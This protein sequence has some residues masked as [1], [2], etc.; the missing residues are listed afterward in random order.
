[1][2][3]LN[4]SVLSGALIDA[5]LRNWRRSPRPYTIDLTISCP[6]LKTYRAAAA[7]DATH[8]I[9]L[10]DAQKVEHHAKG[11]KLLGRDFGAWVYTV[12]GDSGPD[13]YHSFLSNIYR[14]KW[15]NTTPRTSCRH[16]ALH[17]DRLVPTPPSSPRSSGQPPTASSP[18]LSTRPTPLAGSTRGATADAFRPRPRS[19]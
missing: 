17:A 1:M 11:C 2:H 15:P 12:V 9:E 14:L 19:Q 7:S 16:G 4:S 18:S 8:V 5:V 13:A 10:R 3:Y 6:F